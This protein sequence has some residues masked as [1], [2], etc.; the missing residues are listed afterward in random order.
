MPFGQHLGLGLAETHRAR[1]AA[2]LHLP[3]REERDAQDQHERQR[4]DQDIEQDV[5]FFRLLA[6]IFDAVVL[7]QLRQRRV[8]GDGDRAEAVAVLELAE[9]AVLADLHFRNRAFDD[10]GAEIGIADCVGHIGAGAE[11]RHHHQQGE[12]DAP[13]Y[14][15]ALD[16]GIAIRLLIVVHDAGSFLSRPM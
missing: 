15:Q 10:L 16:P 9:D 1:S 3:Q 2:F 14:E 11:H 4:L 6:G 5:G 7:Q 12:E 13:P 8:V